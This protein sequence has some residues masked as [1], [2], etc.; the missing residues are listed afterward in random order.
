VAKVVL[1]GSWARGRH[2]VAS[3]VDVLVVY[4]GPARPDAYARVKRALDVARLEPHVY[5][6]SEHDAVQ[7]VVRRMIEGGIDLLDAPA[8]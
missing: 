7:P 2:T 4:R 5:S 8:R 1:F 3:D 6:D